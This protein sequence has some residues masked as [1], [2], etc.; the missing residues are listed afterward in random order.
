MSGLG[1]RWLLPGLLALPVVLAGCGFQPVYM[2]TAS[3]K[4][5]VAQREL[6]AVYVPIIPDR[7]G[8]LLRQ[9]L[10][11]RLGDDAGGASAYDLQV[12]FA[13]AGEGIGI[14]PDTI[15]TRV[16]LIGTANWTLIAHDAARSTL[17][18]GSAR[19]LDGLNIF[20]EQYFASDLESEAV[21]GRIAENLAQQIT[22][23]LAVW[24]RKRAAQ[25][26]PG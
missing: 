11:K 2:P 4:P 9:A 23:Q 15:A 22:T 14:E 10:Q 17:T 3:G 5:G 7:P 21:Q 26:P 20:D 13:V 24:F 25:A 18:S 19:S 1:R 8:Q 16:R 6:A 12:R